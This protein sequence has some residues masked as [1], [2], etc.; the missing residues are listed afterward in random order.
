[1]PAPQRRSA[2]LASIIFALFSVPAGAQESAALFDAPLV[3]AD[4]RYCITDLLD[5][6]G[7]VSV[8]AVGWFEDRVSGWRNDGSGAFLQAF[9]FQVELATGVPIR[10][11]RTGR[12][13]SD[14]LDDFAFCYGRR[15]VAYR[16]NGAAAPVLLFDLPVGGD[17]ADFALAD[18]DGDG[19]DDAVAILRGYFDR[20]LKLELY[21][22]AGSRGLLLADVREM[23]SLYGP[24][25]LFI[26]ELNGDGLPDFGFFEGPDLFL[27]P[28]DGRV[29]PD[30]TVLGRL[31]GTPMTA[32]GDIDGDGDEDVVI[33]G[34]SAYQVLRRTGPAT[35]T[36][37]PLSFGGPATKL[38]DV[39]G[40]GDL[41]GV[42]CGGGEGGPGLNDAP[43]VFEIA[44]NDG[45]GEF[46]AATQMPGLGSL[47]IA[48]A[49]DVDH[50]GDLDLV[51]GRCVYYARGPL[52]GF[53]RPTL[54]YAGTIPDVPPIPVDADSDGD[55][56]VG[57]ALGETCANRGDGT[58]A[59]RAPALLDPP[60]GIVLV[61]PGLAGDFDGD[62]DADLLVEARDGSGAFV[63]MRILRNCGSGAFS[64]GGR[65]APAGKR[66]LE[67]AELALD[68]SLAAVFDSDGDGDL[69]VVAQNRIAAPYRIRVW[70]NDGAGSFALAQV[71]KNDGL[72][73]AADMNGDGVLDLVVKTPDSPFAGIRNGLGDGRF[74][75]VASRPDGLDL[76]YA[77]ALADLDGDGDVD[78]AGVATGSPPQ[79]VVLVNDG[80]EAFSRSRALGFSWAPLV[81]TREPL[82]VPSDV[83]GDGRLD[84][85]LRLSEGDGN[86]VSAILLRRP[87][88]L[89]F[90]PA[91]RQVFW[92]VRA[93][94]FDGDADDDLIQA[95]CTLRHANDATREADRVIVAARVAPPTAGVRLQFGEGTPG[96][97]GIIPVLG[98]AGPLRPGARPDYRLSGGLGGSTA[99][100]LIGTERRH[101]AVRGGT[102]LVDPRWRRRLPLAGE[103]AE[104][105]TGGIRFVSR[106]LSPAHAGLTL[107]YQAVVVDPA[108]PRGLSFSNGLAIQVGSG[109]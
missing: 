63:E 13:D 27:F 61:G 19:L 98:V 47:R 74:G 88:G 28:L 20:T 69:D 79:F 42:C 1:M 78:I 62:G 104:P 29:L 109:E 8:D 99:V 94:D 30:P 48:G 35:L 102:L 49:A 11:M 40:D 73:G 101:D 57:L 46:A 71:F 97:A 44:L 14:G 106:P 85:I 17:V 38:A 67:V 52:R 107:Y 36:L 16:S 3:F 22:N 39:D 80:N 86:P 50:D 91:L 59:P 81:P 7:D 87:S 60:A 15:I 105:G 65:A 6:D 93:A 53:D 95:P 108:A 41:D 25:G 5:L 56:D 68:P 31:I 55:L 34:L 43:S 37:E 77:L 21:R 9:S 33:F 4:G 75:P 24:E 26:A 100:L 45:T 96:T 54:P 76:S 32:G 12:L 83:N 84:V 10:Q 66:M 103:V 92:A 70:R 72:K 23:P 82:I 90:E 58:F 89:D 64:D 18:F 2:V 51:A